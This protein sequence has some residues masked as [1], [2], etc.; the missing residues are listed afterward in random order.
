MRYIKKIITVVFLAAIFACIFT[1]CEDQIQLNTAM[2]INKDFSGTRVMQL[3]I[4]KSSFESNSNK[5]IDEV[6]S[7]IKSS[8]PS[9]MKLDF[10][11]TGDS[12]QYTF[13][14]EFKNQD[15]YTQKVCAILGRDVTAQISMPNNIFSSGIIVHEDFTSEELLNWVSDAL[16]DNDVTSQS[17][18]FSNNG[19][20]VTACGKVYPVTSS[21]I[22]IS[23]ISYTNVIGI[24]IFTDIINSDTFSR[25]ILIRIPKEEWLVKKEAIHKY[26]SGNVPGECTYAE[27][28]SDSEVTLVFSLKEVS[29][30]AMEEKMK[31][32]LD[33]NSYHIESAASASDQ[34]KNS[35]AANQ[36]SSTESEYQKP[37]NIKTGYTEYLDLSAYAGS[38]SGKITLN[39]YVQKAVGGDQKVQYLSNGEYING[40]L[41]D[42]QNSDY[43]VVEIRDFSA[44]SIQ[45]SSETDYAAEKIELKT[46]LKSNSNVAK[47]VELTIA[48]QPND[49]DKALILE[50]L[51]GLSKDAT[52]I[53]YS[54]T[55]DSQAVITITING[56]IKGVNKTVGSLFGSNN[57]IT[58]F[59][60]KGFFK[61]NKTGVFD[62]KIDLNNF[63]TCNNSVVNYEAAT[64]FG[65]K[66]DKSSPNN[67]ETYS[68]VKVSRHSYKG[69]SENGSLD[70]VFTTN[71]FNYLLLFFS[72]L[73]IAAVVL[74]V[75]LV[76]RRMKIV[77]KEVVRNLELSNMKTLLLAAIT[78][79]KNKTDLIKNNHI[80]ENCLNN[81]EEFKENESNKNE[82]PVKIRLGMKVFAVIAVI[83]FF[84]PMC[85][86]S[87]GSN[88]VQLNGPK[89]SFGFD[90]LG[91]HVDGNLVCI[92]LLIFPIVIVALLFIKKL[93]KISFTEA[94]MALMSLINLGILLAIHFKVT[95]AVKETMCEVDFKF[96]YYLA[97]ISYLLL[98]VASSVLLWLKLKR[99]SAI[100]HFENP[101]GNGE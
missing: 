34:E 83:C 4:S 20:T 52:K 89:L 69:S 22:S 71:S 99:P 21:Q 44:N 10:Q 39:Y 96:G 61:L 7:L 57:S 94:A 45:V 9:E 53:E 101:N 100:K 58:H 82:T 68:N 81:M 80:V 97:A 54:K 35:D 26:A 29:L 98:L 25:S 47:V 55:G 88:S 84:L 38:S 50:N 49:S 63:I 95:E 60:E 51:K 78:N 42:S 14:I 6:A 33:Y 27:E 48:P 75:I 41:S 65:E 24:D 23:D 85:A 66:I 28:E 3:E 13:T 73:I 32:I 1:G 46:E 19:S 67:S 59:K 91:E 15:E 12:Y 16:H 8:C 11:D 31:Q 30:S 93:S 40:L 37:F 18:I 64:S 36:K 77:D 90:V 2:N 92:L 74:A 17:D 79:M 86:V 87:C 43:S 5:S 62:E 76:N 56:D 70:I 72:L